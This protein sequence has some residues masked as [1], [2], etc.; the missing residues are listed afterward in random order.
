MNFS[1]FY[2]GPEGGPPGPVSPSFTLSIQPPANTT[3]NDTCTPE[4]AGSH[5]E[6]D[7]DSN[8][9]WGAYTTTGFSDGT[10]QQYV[11][12]MARFNNEAELT[13]SQW[14]G[15]EPPASAPAFSFNPQNWHYTNNI[16]FAQGKIRS[17]SGGAVNCPYIMAVNA[18]DGTEVWSN[19]YGPSGNTSPESGY[20]NLEWC[21]VNRANTDDSNIWMGGYTTR[22]NNGPAYTIDPVD[23][24]M[25]TGGRISGT[26]SFTSNFYCQDASGNRVISYT[27][28][29][30]PNANTP[31]RPSNGM[32]TMNADM[33]S[34]TSS[35][36]SYN[37]SQTPQPTNYG[38]FNGGD[39]CYG[40]QA[41]TGDGKI[42]LFACSMT[43]VRTVVHNV[44]LEDSTNHLHNPS[45]NTSFFNNTRSMDFDPDTNRMYFA[46]GQN[47]TQFNV[48]CYDFDDNQIV[49]QKT[50]TGNANTNG[51]G[52]DNQIGNNPSYGG[53]ISCKLNGDNLLLSFT[54]RVIPTST[55]DDAGAGCVIIQMPAD[56]SADGDIGGYT[57]ANS[58]RLSVGAEGSGTYANWFSG[59]YNP[60]GTS[61]SYAV[62]TD[63]DNQF[64][65]D[66]IPDVDNLFVPTYF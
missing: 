37:G 17:A 14:N 55:T 19:L 62:P 58:T 54:A 2:F 24:S 38:L 6:A 13:W 12:I 35:I 59:A 10:P 30:S 5:C 57:V 49:W 28:G 46:Y 40:L 22:Y 64:A 31:Q 11:P 4:I 7:P 44:S 65:Y 60:G 16:W 41:Q 45:L 43:D 18:A 47:T 15:F 48:C 53:L 23:G 36:N 42:S 3:G 26:Y 32:F 51:A 39:N 34:Y 63:F 1:V 27:G 66:S 56:G 33:T 29:F 50:V 21:G 25:S 61:S 52:T 9:Y 8:I 20:T